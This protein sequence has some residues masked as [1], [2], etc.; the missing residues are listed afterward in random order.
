MDKRFL[1][2]LLI[3]SPSFLLF[4]GALTMSQIIPPFVIFSCFAW[5]FWRRENLLDQL[6]DLET[7]LKQAENE[8][9]WHGP[10]TGR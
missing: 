8:R 10:A 6:D 1:T 5:L 7:R 9:G 2:C 4:E 3:T